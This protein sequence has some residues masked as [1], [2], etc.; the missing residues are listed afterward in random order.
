MSAVATASTSTSSRST[1][2]VWT[3]AGERLELSSHEFVAGGGEGNVYAIGTR[4]FKIAHDPAAACPPGKRAELAQIGDPHVLSPTGA[5]HRRHGRRSTTV[6]HEMPFATQAWTACELIPLAFRRRH[7]LSPTVIPRLVAQLRDRI[8]AVH[9]AGCRVVDL[10][11]ANVLVS[12]DFRTA[13]LIDVD[14]FQ[15]PS[16]PATAIVPTVADPTR[17]PGDFDESTDWFSFAVL[18]CSLLAGI[19][20]FRGKHPSVK[21]LMARIQA[22]ISI[23]D[24]SV[25]LPRACLPVQSMPNPWR[26][27]LHATL[28]LGQRRPPPHPGGALQLGTSPQPRAPAARLRMQPLHRAHHHV[29]AVLEAQGRLVIHTGSRVLVDGAVR[30]DAA[31]SV[32]LGISPGGH[33]VAAWVEA[34]MLHLHDLD[35]EVALPCT[36]AAREV[37]SARGT[38]YVTCGDT[39]SRVELLDLPDRID[40][41]KEGGPT[42]VAGLRPCVR[43]APQASRLWP[44]CVIQQLLGS[45]TVS[46][47]SETGAAEQRRIPE[48]DGRRIV[49]AVH[50][51][52]VMVVVTQRGDGYERLVFRFR[53]GRGHTLRCQADRP[54]HAAQL[55]V[56]DTGVCVSLDPDDQLELFV[57]A[58]D[59]PTRQRLDD[60]AVGGDWLL[61]PGDGRLLAIVGPRVYEISMRQ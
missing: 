5:L 8:A 61:C 39:V 15:T 26:D 46:L 16:F 60:P 32:A 53:P 25:R 37:T 29:R 43:V 49:D 57:R 17:A 38:L 28:Q 2:T 6:G 48:L 4:G 9:A 19:H 40:R 31:E 13:M 36:A 33:P 45:T 21:G 30:L 41:P 11:E 50:D 56:L 58:P 27:W 12:K 34:G 7:A 55:V 59:H 23:F 1:L 35:R 22:G 14:S 42:L 54:A 52:H 18:T 47:L 10:N 24:P 44:G 51:R 20:P 3:D